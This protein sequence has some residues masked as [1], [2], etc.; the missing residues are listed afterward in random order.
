MRIS[1]EAKLPF[2]CPICGKKAEY[3]LE[4]LKEGATLSCPFCKLKLILHGH[5][6]EDVKREMRKLG[7]GNS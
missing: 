3:P 5:M 4:E 1:M 6:W 7:G 2:S